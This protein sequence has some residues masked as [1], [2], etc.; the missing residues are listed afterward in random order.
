MSMSFCGQGCLDVGNN[1]KVI[2]LQS[3]QL[4]CDRYVDKNS[5]TSIVSGLLPNSQL[6]GVGLDKGPQ[7]Q[8]VFTIELLVKDVKFT[9]KL[10]GEPT[11]VGWQGCQGGVLVTRNSTAYVPFWEAS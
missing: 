1:R 6:N 9:I 7:G 4:Q 8:N 10:K 2:S 11:E 3:R 5:K